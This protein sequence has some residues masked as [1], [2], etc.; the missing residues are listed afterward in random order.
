MTTDVKTLQ[1]I[2]A[3]TLNQRLKGTQP[4]ILINAL[5]K[6]AYIAKHIPGSINIPTENAEMAENIIP[7][8]DAEIVVYC[9]NAD[10]TASPELAE[11]L[12]DMGYTNVIDFQEGLA[13]WRS[14]GYK[15]V[16]DEI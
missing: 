15:L 4:P 11:K 1:R 5:A 7:Y 14:A 9:A 10:C 6:D 13:G 16:G 3:E 2:D 12:E 8:K